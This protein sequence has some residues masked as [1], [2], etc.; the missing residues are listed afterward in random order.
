[1]SEEYARILKNAMSLSRIERMSLA[2]DILEGLKEG[3]GNSLTNSQLEELD[4]RMHTFEE[5][6][7]ILIPGTE[8]M[9][10]LEAH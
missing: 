8:A 9:R 1:M 6:E 7:S 10:Q 2:Q 3:E 4:R 5:G